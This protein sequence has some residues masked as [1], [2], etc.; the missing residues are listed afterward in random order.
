MPTKKD[1]NMNGASTISNADSAAI[2]API[3]SH[4]KALFKRYALSS[5][6]KIVSLLNEGDEAEI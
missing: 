2:S 4:K 3:N 1:S 5:K 6:E